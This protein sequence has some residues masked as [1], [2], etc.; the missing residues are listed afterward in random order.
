MEEGLYKRHP[1][2]W[3]MTFLDPVG[4]PIN[5][6]NGWVKGFLNPVGVKH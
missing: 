4:V 3:V 6:H 5:H 2:K 1:N